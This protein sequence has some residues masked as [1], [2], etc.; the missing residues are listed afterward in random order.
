MS[1]A[2]TSGNDI[3]RTDN[4]QDAERC[5]QTSVIHQASG[6]YNEPLYAGLE[7]YSIDNAK[8]AL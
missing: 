8:R 3:G 2:A 4:A 1:I 5:R 6:A 7:W